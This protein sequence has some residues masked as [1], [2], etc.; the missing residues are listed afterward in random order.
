M[1]WQAAEAYFT[2]EVL[3]LT[4]ED[5]GY[6]FLCLVVTEDGARHRSDTVGP[7][8]SAPPR[9]RACGQHACM[10]WVCL[11]PPSPRA[12]LPWHWRTGRILHTSSRVSHCWSRFA[13]LLNGLSDL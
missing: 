2:P 7:V 1:G 8:V 10:A 5:V 6:M 11:P 3:F 12:H 4:A 13:V 9:V